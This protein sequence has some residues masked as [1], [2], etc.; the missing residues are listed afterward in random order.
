MLKTPEQTPADSYHLY[1]EHFIPVPD[2]IKD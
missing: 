1:K 2:H